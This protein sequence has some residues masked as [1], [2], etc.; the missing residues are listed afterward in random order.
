MSRKLSDDLNNPYLFSEHQ[1]GVYEYGENGVGGKTATGSLRIAE[2]PSRDGKAQSAAGGEN[3][4]GNDHEWGADDGGHLI[5]A[6]F[7]GETGEA[8][9]TAQNRNLNRSD[10][11]HMENEWAAHLEAGDKVF[12]HI[13]TDDAQRPNAYMG[14]VIYESPDGT[15]DYDTFHM[16]NESRSEI[17]QWEADAEAFEA[18][19]LYSDIDS[20][21]QESTSNM[22]T[23]YIGEAST[24]GESEY[25][26]ENGYLG[27]V[28]SVETSSEDSQSSESAMDK[29]SSMEN[30]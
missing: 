29:D 4:R 22:D 23:D 7:G 27:T 8:N 13:E 5:G 26:S 11:K 10:Y 3:R 2:D 21:T 30:D 19:Q 14:Y 16:V 9:L 18:S 25:N 12:V 1:A 15:R 28:A 6:R 20:K 24:P 17:A